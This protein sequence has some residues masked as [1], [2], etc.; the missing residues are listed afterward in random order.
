MKGGI[1]GVHWTDVI[2][3]GDPIRHGRSADAN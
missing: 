2:A 3:A 1:A